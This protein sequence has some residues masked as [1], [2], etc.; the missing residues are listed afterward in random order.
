MLV[1]LLLSFGRGKVG[2]GEKE[3]C[4]SA[5]LVSGKSQIH[6]FV[7]ASGTVQMLLLGKTTCQIMLLVENQI[8][9]RVK[10]KIV[11]RE[12]CQIVLLSKIQIVLWC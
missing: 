4:R 9:L 10:N 12:S 5:G 2:L 1:Q 6:G 8:M 11:L 3:P 7:P